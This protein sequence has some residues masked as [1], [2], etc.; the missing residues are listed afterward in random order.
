MLARADLLLLGQLTVERLLMML[1]V[2]PAEV[3]VTLPVSAAMPAGEL[4]PQAVPL[5]VLET[6]YCCHQLA[7]QQA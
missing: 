4:H 1:L 3:V 6:A 5:Q 2:L 7:V